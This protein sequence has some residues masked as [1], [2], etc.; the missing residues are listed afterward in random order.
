MTNGIA[1]SITIDRYKALQNVT[2]GSV[3]A[4]TII[5]DFILRKMAM[6]CD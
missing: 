4:T 2:S 3:I 1:M 6:I 5:V